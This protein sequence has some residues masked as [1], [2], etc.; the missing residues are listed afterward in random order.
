M[1]TNERSF[2]ITENGLGQAIGH[3]VRRNYVSSHPTAQLPGVSRVIWGRP[4]S[5][6]FLTVPNNAITCAIRS[7][8]A[9]GKAPPAPQRRN[10]VVAFPRQ[11]PDS[12]KPPLKRCCDAC[13]AALHSPVQ[14]IRMA[15]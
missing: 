3:G 15:G 9:L 4:V 11:S 1:K 14:A 8:K 12:N 5:D 7:S 2:F 10:R 13:Q 6:P